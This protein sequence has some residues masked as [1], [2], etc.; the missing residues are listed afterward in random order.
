MGN[1]W[2]GRTTRVGY[3]YRSE[4]LIR[5]MTSSKRVQDRSKKKRVHDLEVTT[6]KWKIA[7]KIIYLMELLKQEPEMVIA[8]RSLEHH[9]RQ[10]N[11]P[12][13]HRVSDFLRK[14]PNLFELYKDQ[15]GVLWCGM[16]SKAENLM[17]QQQRVIEEHADKETNG[18]HS[19][20]SES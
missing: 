10:I 6:E 3:S 11:L 12:K 7:S 16:T 2:L 1:W 9:R 19:H 18:L 5:W 14:T 17:E 8:V 20:S 4:F 15:K 13:P